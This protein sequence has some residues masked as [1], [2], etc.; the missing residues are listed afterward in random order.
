MGPAMPRRVRIDDRVHPQL[1]RARPPAQVEIDAL[2]TG[3]GRDAYGASEARDVESRTA[4]HDFSFGGNAKG[5]AWSLNPY[6]GCLHHCA[7]CYVPDTMKVDRRRWGT[8][9]V[10]KQNLPQI[11][12]REV[13]TKAPL[14]VY[15]ST[16]TDPY[17]AIEGEREVTRRCLEVLGARDWPLEVLTRS[18][19][20][21]RDADVLRR[22][23]RLRVGLS[24]PTL[25]EASRRLI[26]PAAPA[27][28][29][30]LRTLGKLADEGFTTFA[31][32][33]PAYPPTDFTMADVARAFRDAGVKW[34]NTSFWRR[35]PSW[36]PKVWDRLA[37]TAWEDF[38][39]FVANEDEQARVRRDL[40]AALKAVG[41]PL[42]TGFFNPPFPADAPST[43]DARLGS[44]EAFAPRFA[45]GLLDPALLAPTPDALY[46]EVDGQ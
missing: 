27:I 44:A 25:C 17:Q 6:V 37:G 3:A 22:F 23:T 33:S 39:R 7:Y 21:H 8:Y 31:N 20:V 43:R 41:I 9:V 1:R 13:A 28:P 10:V 18:P 45:A 38:A 46:P 24:V 29:S 35:Q 12:R 26:E 16:A 30:R 14:T 32:Y 15:L 19:L 4:L 34:V 36:L 42:R 40:H 2:A 5:I 11:L